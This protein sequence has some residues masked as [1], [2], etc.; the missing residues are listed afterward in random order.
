MKAKT[1]SSL[2]SDVIVLGYYCYFDIDQKIKNSL[3][4][5]FGFF[6]FICLFVCGTQGLHLKP[7][8]QPYFCEGYHELFAQAGFEP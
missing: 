8:H 5:T 6:L 2:S 7:L 4:R 1:L 3:K